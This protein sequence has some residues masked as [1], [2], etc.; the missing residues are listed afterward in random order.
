MLTIITNPK[1]GNLT[2]VAPEG[3]AICRADETGP[4]TTVTMSAPKGTPESAFV[5]C[6]Y[7]EPQSDGPTEADKDAALRRFGV[8]V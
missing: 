4:T 5:E 8:E 1:T 2:F 3:R 6:D 7:G